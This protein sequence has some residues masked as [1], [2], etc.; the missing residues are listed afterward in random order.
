M[1][2]MSVTVEQGTIQVAPN[3]APTLTADLL[4]LLQALSSFANSSAALSKESLLSICVC[5]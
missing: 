4:R 2:T 5:L 1:D 3:T